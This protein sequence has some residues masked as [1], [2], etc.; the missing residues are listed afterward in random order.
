[1]FLAVCCVG[2]G[3]EKVQN[4]SHEGRGFARQGPWF[5]RKMG[6]RGKQSL[7]RVII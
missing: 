1:M 3:E 6:V 4:W 5:F 7:E 2:A